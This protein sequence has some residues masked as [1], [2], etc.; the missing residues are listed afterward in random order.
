MT[1]YDIIHPRIT[2]QCAGQDSS[3]HACGATGGW[4]WVRIPSEKYIGNLVHTTLLEPE[5]RNSKCTNFRSSASPRGCV[6]DKKCCCRWNG[7]ATICEAL[8]WLTINTFPFTTCSRFCMQ[9]MWFLCMRVSSNILSD[10][11]LFLFS[12]DAAYRRAWGLP[13]HNE[14]LVACQQAQNMGI[15]GYMVTTMQRLFHIDV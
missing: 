11:I 14:S 6:H 3:R 7:A 9:E 10:A 15:D 4:N 2:G 5:F 8:L 12:K 13:F 1:L